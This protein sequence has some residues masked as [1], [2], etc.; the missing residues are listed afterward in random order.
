[1]CQ[2]ENFRKIFLYFYKESYL[3]TNVKI[4][5]KLFP[6]NEKKKLLDASLLEKKKK[7]IKLVQIT[8]DKLCSL[9]GRQKIP[10]SIGG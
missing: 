6:V 8:L 3:K 7:G 1:M 2:R 10:S 4:A 9:K 5:S